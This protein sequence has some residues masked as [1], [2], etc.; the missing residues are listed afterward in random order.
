MTIPR[1]AM[2][3]ALLISAAACTPA[4]KAASPAPGPSTTAT[5]PSEPQ[6][7]PV[8]APTAVAQSE[9]EHPEASVVRLLHLTQSEDAHLYSTAGGDPAING[10][11]TYLAVFQSP[12]DG[13]QVFELGDFN[14]WKLLYERPGQIALQVSRSFIDP[15]G[16]VKTVEE[17][18]LVNVPKPGETSLQV[19][20]AEKAN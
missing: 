12:M 8:G 7:R 14:D 11:Y 18:L 2:L 6:L 10:L 19:S 5:A 16:E 3:L 15:A 17:F 13:N 9:G 4:P 1:R 20:K